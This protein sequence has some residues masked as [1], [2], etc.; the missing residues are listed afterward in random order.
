M[1]SSGLP[2]LDLTRGPIGK[3]LLAFALPTL[4]SNALQSLN[5]SVNAIWVGGYLGEAP[6]TAVTNSNAVLFLL[7]GVVFGIVMA[8]GIMVGHAMGA[9]DVDRAKRVVGSS[10]AFIVILSLLTALLGAATVRPILLLMGTP[11]DALPYAVSYMRLVFFATPAMFFYIYVAMTLRGAGDAKTP[12]IFMFVSVGLDIALNPLLIFGWGPVPALGISGSALAMLISQTT[13]LTAMLV[14]LYRRK[15]FLCIRRHELHYLRMD[16]AILKVLVLRGIPMGL[17]MIIVSSSMLAMLGLI[18]HF[19]TDVTAAFGAAMQLWTYIQMPAFA[20]GSAVTVMAAQSIGAGHWDRVAR[21]TWAGVGINGAITGAMIMLV[22]LFNHTAVGFFLPRDSTAID[23]AAHINA[24][25][26][27]SF[28]LFGATMVLMGV[29][30]STGA[31]I[32]PLIILFGSMW[33]ARIPFAY[34]MA[35]RWQAD[36]VWW[37]FPLGSVVALVLGYVYYRYGD[38]RKVQMMPQAKMPVPQAVES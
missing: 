36:A 27:W 15:H 38:W 35:P 5:A 14:L 22:Y 25:V 30:R 12:F 18:N 37:S 2:A 6:L 28:V 20:I 23:I 4:G 29:V 10:A 3:T 8:T 1:P 24:I 13:T 26:L 16:R 9:R 32:G 11:P 17:Q 34:A 31:V 19:G 7:M 21:I 33:L